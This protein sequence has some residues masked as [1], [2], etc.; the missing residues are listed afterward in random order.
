M[1]FGGESMAK[2]SSDFCEDGALMNVLSNAEYDRKFQTEI[3]FFFSLKLFMD[4]CSIS[5]QV[6]TKVNCA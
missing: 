1:G 5:E 4:S 3:N 2:I 6:L